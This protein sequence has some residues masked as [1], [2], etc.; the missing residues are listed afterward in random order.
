VPKSGAGHK[1]ENVNASHRIASPVTT[2]A[3]I[4]W[5]DWCGS[6]LCSGTNADRIA[7]ARS[8]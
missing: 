8:H 1:A 7:M 3:E 4:S 2:K 5:T 6:G